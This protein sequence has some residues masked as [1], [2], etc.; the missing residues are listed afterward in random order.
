MGK[1]RM[2]KFFWFLFFLVVSLIVGGTLVWV[3]RASLAAQILHRK[4]GVPVSVGS[5]DLTRTSATVQNLVIGNPPRY[6]Q[7]NACT[8][9]TIDITSSW[10]HI[11]GNPLV[12]DEIEMNDLV[13]TLE[14][15]KKKNVTNWDEILKHN[16]KPSSRHYLIRTLILRTLTVQVVTANGAIKRYP[17]LD[18]LEFH[19]ISDETGFPVSEIEKAIFN[20]VMQDLFQRF[21]LQKIFEQLVPSGGVPFLPL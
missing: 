18:R 6:K 5:L 14:Y 3:N 7:P 2:R 20:R 12:I 9:R 16:Q 15:S 4:L 8:A 11:R 13:I 21:N 19:N 17:T 10:S 1:R